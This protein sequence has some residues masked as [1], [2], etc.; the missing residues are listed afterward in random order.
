M[1]WC[2]EDLL[3]VK[4]LSVASSN[5]ADQHFFLWAYNEGDV[6]CSLHTYI[7]HDIKM[8]WQFDYQQQNDSWC[9]LS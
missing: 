7:M 5:A 2:G 3:G 4:S 6:E 1:W 8:F 9:Y